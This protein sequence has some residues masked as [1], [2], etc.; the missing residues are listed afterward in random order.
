MKHFV[1]IILVVVWH[2]TTYSQIIDN[3]IP[4]EKSH[5]DL[6]IKKIELNP[7]FTIIH[8]SITNKITNGWFCAD[9]NIY[10]K[11]STGNEKFEII[12]SEGI[13]TCP[14]QHQFKQIGEILNFKLI[15]PPLNQ[16][17]KTIDIVEDCTDHCFYFKGVVLDN[18]LN[19]VFRLYEK[20]TQL[21]LA[22]DYTEAKKCFNEIINLVPDT[23]NE[24]NRSAQSYLTAILK[25]GK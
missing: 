12:K 11:N 17:I 22:K 19:Q 1:F 21:Y 9:R 16:Q 3:P 6:I 20:G 13:P 8:L 7:Q 25:L 23:Q 15:F 10:I 14:D 18:K 5:A 2:T 4:A 24:Y